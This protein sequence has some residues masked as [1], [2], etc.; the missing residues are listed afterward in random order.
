MKK[1]ILLTLN[2][3]L[4]F[5]CVTCTGQNLKYP[6]EVDN[7]IKQV[8]NNL[9]GWVHTGENDTWS[10]EER[11]KQLNI[12]GVSIAVINDYK[13]EWA[14]GYGFADEQEKR[15]VTGKT[16]FQAASISKSLNSLGI[17][18]LVEENKLDLNSDI[19]NYLVTWKLPYDQKFKNYPVTLREI[20]SHTA[21]LTVHGF[22]GYER[23]KEIPALPMILDGKAPANTAAI[24]VFTE[25]GQQ[26]I[27]S[28]G[29]T[30]ISQLIIT[31]VTKQSY[32]DYMQKNV[33]D[34][35]GMTSSS[36]RQPP[37]DNLKELLAT[38]YLADGTEV[39]G[40]YHIYPEQAAAGLWTNPADL[41]KYI[42]ETQLAFLGKSGK[43]L[44][45]EMTKLRLT[46][47]LQDAALGTFVNT[48]VA[49]S[50]RYFNHNGGNA[51]FTCTA[52]G[53]LD[54]GK[55]AVIMTN[56]ENGALLEE[57]LNSIATVYKWKDFYFPENKKTQKIPEQ[58]LSQYI[59]RYDLDGAT[60]IV[61]KAGDGL[62]INI[63]GADWK[64][65][66]TSDSD[67]FIREYKGAFRFRTGADGKAR[68][69]VV[70]GH[71]LKRL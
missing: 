42:I 20:L 32:S 64:L 15:P 61:K 33:L 41:C 55:G 68:A 10:L 29:G 48:R 30:T 60:G 38:G 71:E 27:Y 17:L 11:M 16:L 2:C 43:V 47:V 21:G 24:R 69:I 54:E 44:S 3:L 66:F 8:E 67:F 40:K 22:P 5:V 50:A 51:G 36:Y 35:L 57:I 9:S 12:K 46:P 49:G 39:K 58:Q 13:V 56:T 63:V 53:S 45:T 59:G 25:P 26:V 23:G 7:R 31:D 70:D 6:A 1:T 14:K 28:G 4:I 19:N 65:Y 37:A 18:K 34:P 52:Y 62:A